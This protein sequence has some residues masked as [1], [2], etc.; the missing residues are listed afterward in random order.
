MLCVW[1][2]D[3]VELVDRAIAYD[4]LVIVNVKGHK[5]NVFVGFNTKIALNITVFGVS[6]EQSFFGTHEEFVD[7]PTITLTELIIVNVLLSER[8]TSLSLEVGRC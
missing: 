3:E 5:R 7:C 6:C 4:G 8:I 1:L 2:K